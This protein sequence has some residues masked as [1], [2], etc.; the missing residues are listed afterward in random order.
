MLRNPPAKQLADDERVQEQS[1]MRYVNYSH[2]DSPDDEQTTHLTARIKQQP[3]Y[4]K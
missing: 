2:L 3:S 4:V 1:A